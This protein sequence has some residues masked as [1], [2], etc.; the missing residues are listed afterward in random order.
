MSLARRAHDSTVYWQCLEELLQDTPS[1]MSHAIDRRFRQQTMWSQPLGK[2]P[3]HTRK[4]L[5]VVGHAL[6]KSLEQNPLEQ[7]MWLNDDSL[8]RSP[9]G[10][11]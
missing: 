1:G 10:G 11:F 6:S 5:A 3:P 7:D 2:T 4:P 8:K 9:R